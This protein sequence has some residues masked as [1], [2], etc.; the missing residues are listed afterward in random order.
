MGSRLLTGTRCPPVGLGPAQ[1]TQASPPRRRRRRPALPGHRSATRTADFW[2]GLDVHQSDSIL[3]NRLKRV[4]RDA[5]G[6][7]QND[8]DGAARQGQ[9]TAGLDSM[10]ASRARSPAHRPPASQPR[11]RRRRPAL[12]GHRRATRAAGRRA[13]LDLLQPDSVPANRT[14]ASLPRRRRRLTW[15]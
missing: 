5:G 2:P 12:S 10:F 15:R 13:G 9:Q 8:P 7:H 11:R 4:H 1:R 14:Q 3:H 6:V